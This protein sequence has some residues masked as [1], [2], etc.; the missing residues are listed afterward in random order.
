MQG[1]RRRRQEITRIVREGAVHSQEELL[2]LLDDRGFRIT[3]PTLSR[4]IRALGLAKTPMGWVLP[5]EIAAGAE[6]A[7]TGF[8]PPATRVGRFE[9]AVLEYVL[10]VE[11]SGQLVVARTPPAGAQPVARALDQAELPGVVGTVA[12]DDTL[13]IATKRPRVA[14]EL[15][16]RMMRLLEPRRRGAGR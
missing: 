11:S 8:A 12:G 10:Q 5:E 4:D 15:A 7:T 6:G 2:G 3:Q 9:Q 13:F 16:R 1:T 14:A